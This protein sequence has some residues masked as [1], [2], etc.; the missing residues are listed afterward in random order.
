MK[1]R[2]QT[3]LG[4]QLVLTPQLRQALHM[5]Q[6]AT[7]DGEFIRRAYLDLV[8]SIPSVAQTRAYLEDTSPNK[9]EKLIAQLLKSPAHPT[10]LANTWRA[11][12]LKPTDDPTSLQNEQGLQQWL[13]GKFSENVRY[14]R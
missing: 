2:L 6:L 4:Q 13:R 10:H 11:L 14:D 7:S 8:G 9:R 1:P 12:V 3:S 5:L